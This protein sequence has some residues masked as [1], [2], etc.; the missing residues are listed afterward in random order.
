MANI[1]PGTNSTSP[2]LTAEGIV[3]W[4]LLAIATYESSPISNPDKIYAVQ[5]SLNIKD[6]TFN[7]T[8]A[9]PCEQSSD[10]LGRVTFAG[11]NYLK[12]VP[13]TPGDPPGTFKSNTLPAYAV[14][15]IMY[16]QNLEN[17][18]E[19][20]PQN[21]NNITA[22]YDSEKQQLIGTVKIPCDIYLDGTTGTGK[23]DPREYIR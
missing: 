13:F 6:F 5:G 9:F 3:F 20:N 8:F 15:S 11:I 12:N 22:N 18:R 4:C 14:E 2:A 21:V 19:L 17:N 16:L 23:F 10:H 7:I 1:Q